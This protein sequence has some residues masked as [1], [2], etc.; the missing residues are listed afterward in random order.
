MNLG[1]SD[2]IK[3]EFSNIYPVKRE[4]IQTTN[5]PDPNWISGFVSGEGNFDAG[6]R[7]ATNSVGSIKSRKERAYL[8]FRVSQ[9]ERDIQLME[10]IILYLG[11]GRIEK[12]SRKPLIYLVIGNFSDIIQIIIPFFNKYPILGIKILDYQD[13]RKIANIINSGCHLT[14]E[15]FE[16]IRQIESGMNRGRKN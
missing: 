9:H 12:D 6:I 13:W 4:I 15:G 5:I 1:V 7:K 2:K 3:S 10:L 11:V 14:N 16:E 8:R